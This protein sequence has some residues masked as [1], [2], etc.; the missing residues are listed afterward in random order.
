MKIKVLLNMVPCQ[1]EN[2]CE[3]LGEAGCYQIQSG[4]LEYPEDGNC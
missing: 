3:Y 1:L 4:P 2:S